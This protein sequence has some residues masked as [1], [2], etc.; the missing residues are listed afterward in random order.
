VHGNARPDLLRQRAEQAA[1]ADLAAAGF[2]WVHVQARGD[3]AELVG[4]APGEDARRAAQ[5]TAGALLAR[6]VGVPGVFT[7]IDARLELAPAP[8]A[9]A[10]SSPAGAAAEPEAAAATPG[11]SAAAPLAATAPAAEAAAAKASAAPTRPGASAT[12]AAAPAPRSDTTVAAG[13]ANDAQLRPDPQCQRELQ[14]LQQLHVLHFHA[15]AA[16]FDLGQEVRLDELAALLKRCTAGR[17]LVHGLRETAALALT[18]ADKSFAEGR[19]EPVMGP[20]L[21]AQRRA[22]SLRAELVARG[23]APARLELGASAREVSSDEQPRVQ[24][25]LTPQARGRTP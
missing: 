6:Y 13:V 21:L 15:G 24:L 1:T 2:D 22:Q 14:D 4:R 23:V 8:V 5:A 19:G 25:T 9:Q 20:L 12:V 16:T 18:S 10:A 17:V 11:A 3:R 7:G